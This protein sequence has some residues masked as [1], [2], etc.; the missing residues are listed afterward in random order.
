MKLSCEGIEFLKQSSILANVECEHEQI[1]TEK[2]PSECP[3]ADSFQIL[4]QHH[5]KYLLV[6][7]SEFLSFRLKHHISKELVGLLLRKK[8][9]LLSFLLFQIVTLTLHNYEWAIPSYLSS[10]ASDGMLHLQTNLLSAG[11]LLAHLHSFAL[12]INLTNHLRI[13]I[14]RR[15]HLSLISS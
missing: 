12:L 4:K 15:N 14:V 6:F 2:A 3:F 13:Q 10:Y 8:L 5:N 11:N 9:L 7:H 1:E